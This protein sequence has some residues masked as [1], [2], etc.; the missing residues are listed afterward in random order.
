[1]TNSI[2][3]EFAD[4]T[5]TFALPLLRIK[6]LQAKTG[7]GIG[8]LF[9][10]V[11]KGCDQVDGKVV[12]APSGAAFYAEDVVE[13]IRQGLIGGDSAIV[14]GADIKVPAGLANRLIDS[15]VLTKP[16]SEAWSL[17]AAILFACIVGYEGK[18]KDQQPSSPAETE[19][20]ITA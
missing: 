6:E 15:Y 7:I 4:G 5:Y 1:M 19:P 13:T 3:L 8:G 14:D 2:E 20:S 17:A 16:L 9:A 12:M 10:R 11:L 18:K